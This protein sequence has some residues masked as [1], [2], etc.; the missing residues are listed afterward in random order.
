MRR[1]LSL[2]CTVALLASASLG[3]AQ[4]VATTPVGFNTAT[5]PAA[6]DVNTPSNIALSAAFYAP[7]IFTG[8]VASVDSTNQISLSGAAFGTSPQQLTVTPFLARMKS[9]ASVGRFFIITANTATQVTLD[10]TTAGYTLVTAS[11]T[12][13][14]TQVNVG[15][16]V[17]ILPANTFG[18]LFGTSSVPFQTGATANSAD[19]IQLFNGTTWDVYFNNGTNWKKSGNG[20]NQ[21]NTVILPDRG[22][23]VIRRGTSALSLTFLGTV[24]STTEKTDFPGPGS[25]FRANRFPVDMTFGGTGL[26]AVNLQNLPNWQSGATANTADNLY[27]WNT[28]NRT[29]DV[30]FYNGTNWKKSGNGLNQNSTAIPAGSAM[31]VVRQSSASGATSTLTQ[32]LPYTLN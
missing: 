12:N 7:A 25:T 26:T 17:E 30:Y 32:T 22:M 9:G 8:A 23:F 18:T 10:T 16:S 3:L 24:P 15:D 21:N 27:L 4:T 28:T 2:I 31:F 5:V 11:P 19:N 29:W 6:L 14:Q 13:T 1:I 20:L